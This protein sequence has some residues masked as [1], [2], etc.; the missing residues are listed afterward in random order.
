MSGYI[1]PRNIPT[2]FE[3]NPDNLWQVSDVDGQTD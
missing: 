1:H 3:K 2:K